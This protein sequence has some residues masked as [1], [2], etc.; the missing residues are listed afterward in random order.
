[1]KYGLL[2]PDSFRFITKGNRRVG[3]L[4]VQEATGWVN[5]SE[6]A[7]AGE[8][9]LSGVLTVIERL[10]AGR[11]LSFWN[12]FVRDSATALEGRGY[13]VSAL[14]NTTLMATSLEGSKP[15]SMASTLGTADPR[16]VCQLLDHY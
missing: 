8:Q 9:S 16:F 7:L 6:V 4:E 10:S 3:Y 1:M 2:K 5:V 11:W 12:T 13:V 14:G 15:E